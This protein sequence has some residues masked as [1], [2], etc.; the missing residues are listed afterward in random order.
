MVPIKM[1]PIARAGYARRALSTAAPTL[2][3]T[4]EASS[5]K[6]LA[7]AADFWRRSQDGVVLPELG[8]K[9][10]A[11]RRGSYESRSALAT[12]LSKSWTV[13]QVTA[14]MLESHVLSAYALRVEGVDLGLMR[15]AIWPAGPDGLKT[16]LLFSLQSDPALPLSLAA[17][18]LV[19]HAKGK[20]TS[21]E[22]GVQRVMGI[23]ALPGLSLQPHHMRLEP[24][25]H[26][27]TACRGP[28]ASQHCL[29]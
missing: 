9:L 2:G 8:L 13:E 15:A 27:V 21:D 16:A 11:A 1:Q 28:W 29:L 4:A 3:R 26:T 12:A 10:E 18:P 5:P 14:Q 7:D 22:V 25:S 19:H 17:L 6:R 23:A 20:L 24:P